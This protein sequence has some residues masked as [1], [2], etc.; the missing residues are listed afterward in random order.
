MGT[1]QY[2]IKWL[3]FFRDIK[4]GLEAVSKAVE[5]FDSIHRHHL[6]STWF[7]RNKQVTSER[8]ERW[9]EPSLRL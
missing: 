1:R 6:T 5:I 9:E 2:F 4:G 3:F 7:M 8:I